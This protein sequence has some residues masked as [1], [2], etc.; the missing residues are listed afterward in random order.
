MPHWER[1]RWCNEISAINEQRN[2][3]GDGTPNQPFDPEAADVPVID[4]DEDENP[5]TD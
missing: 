3:D 2:E 1:K 4:L 5:F